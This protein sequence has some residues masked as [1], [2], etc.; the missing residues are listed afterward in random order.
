MNKQKAQETA[1]WV[2]AIWA[3]GLATL[4]AWHVIPEQKTGWDVFVQVVG[5]ATAIGTVGA[6]G[7]AMYVS[8]STSREQSRRD[9]EGAVILA[10]G[11]VDL[12]GHALGRLGQSSAAIAFIQLPPD[13][14][15]VEARKKLDAT[16]NFLLRSLNSPAFSHGF[17]T[18][19][20]LSPLPNKCAI[21]M[22]KAHSMAMA[23]RHDVEGK[24]QSGEWKSADSDARHALLD[25]WSIA[26]QEII[27]Y[28]RHVEQDMTEIVLNAGVELTDEERYGGWSDDSDF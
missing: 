6:L 2:F 24:V 16:R 28:G 3:L 1:V 9:F 7:W 23:L 17:E 21:R 14:M 12:L 5:V 27:T 20:K 13:Y 18:I 15:P 4:I 11:M 25:H 10:A 22:Y 8:Y 26:V 19:S